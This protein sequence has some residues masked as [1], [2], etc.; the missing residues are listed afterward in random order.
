ME[1]KEYQEGV[2][3]RLSLYLNTLKE[4]KQDALV[5]SK[6]RKERKLP[7]DWT[8]SDLN[9]CKRAWEELNDKRLLPLIPRKVI[10]KN[11]A[12]FIPKSQ[13]NTLASYKSRFSGI[14]RPVP[15]VCLKVPTGGGKTLLAAGAI[16]HINTGFF[17][18]NKGFVLWVV[19]SDSIYKQ[20]M[21]ALLD[22][23]SLYRQILDRASHGKVKILQKTDSFHPQDIKELFMYYAF[24]ASV[25]GKAN[26]RD[27]EDV[28][29]F[30]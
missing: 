4:K 24:N 28:Q 9:F 22:R 20:T 12:L 13:E 2:L 29:R 19:P 18:Q 11:E 10:D 3:E 30:R 21:K 26:K 23:E 1:L 14:K 17:E 16:E 8:S 27:F 7:V 15:N 5:L 6:S 25:C